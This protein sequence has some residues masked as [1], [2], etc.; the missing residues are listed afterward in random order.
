MWVQEAVIPLYKSRTSEESADSSD[1]LFV[2]NQELFGAHVIL[3]YERPVVWFR[4]ERTGSVHRES[5]RSYRPP[6]CALSRQ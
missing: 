1:V 2:F 5:I 3:S 6:V 4:S